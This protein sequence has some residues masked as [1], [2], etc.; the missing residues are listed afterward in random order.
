MRGNTV[1]A[2]RK[3]VMAAMGRY[4]SGLAKSMIGNFRCSQGGVE[5]QNKA[6]LTR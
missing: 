5:N 2:D 4:L 6:R 3:V 1:F